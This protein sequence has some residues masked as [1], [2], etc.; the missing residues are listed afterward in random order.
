MHAMRSML[1]CQN[2]NSLQAMHE[3]KCEGVLWLKVTLCC[4]YTDFWVTSNVFL[5]RLYRSPLVTVAA[6]KGACPAGGCCL[7]LCC[8]VRIMTEQVRLLSVD[9]H[10]STRMQR[11]WQYAMA[12]CSLCYCA[13]W[14]HSRANCSFHTSKICESKN[15]EVTIHCRV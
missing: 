5:A 2:M 1:N 9:Q 15:M 13:I 8:D 14:C 7:S 10:I 3:G 12:P 4:R 6:I 11:A